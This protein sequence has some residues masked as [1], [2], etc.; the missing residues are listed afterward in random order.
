VK[1]HELQIF[2]KKIDLEKWNDTKL[3]CGTIIH[4]PTF[5]ES[6]LNYLAS[7]PGNAI[8]LPYHGRLVQFHDLITKK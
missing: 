7:N 8:Y 5:V 6:H 1:L 4:A 3:D 2:F